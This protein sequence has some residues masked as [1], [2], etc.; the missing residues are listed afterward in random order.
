M[1]SIT[2]RILTISI[3]FDDEI[4]IYFDNPSGFKWDKGLIK[5]N[6]LYL[7]KN[8]PSDFEENFDIK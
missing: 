6:L 2:K 3:Y 4:T 5:G 8:N 7:I 1:K